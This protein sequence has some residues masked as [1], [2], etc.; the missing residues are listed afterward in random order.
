MANALLEV[1][2]PGDSERVVGTKTNR[3]GAFRLKRIRS[4]DYVFKVTLNG[5]QSVVG[6]LRVVPGAKAGGT[7][8][9][10][11]ETLFRV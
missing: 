10:P 8:I 3:D 5:F 9:F 6:R 7:G 2:G 4:G 11:W 1:R